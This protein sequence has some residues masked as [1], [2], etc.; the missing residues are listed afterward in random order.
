MEAVVTQV[1]NDGV[2]GAAMALLL[3]IAY[4]L[5]RM[6]I[7][8]ESESNCCRCLRLSVATHNPGGAA[9]QLVV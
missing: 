9:E 2:K 7:T 5:Y 1:I 6:Q 3:V 4:K 8:T